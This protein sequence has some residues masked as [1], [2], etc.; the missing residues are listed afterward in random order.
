MLY[1]ANKMKSDHDSPLFGLIYDGGK[2]DVN[3]FI[4]LRTLKTGLQY[5]YSRP[6]RLIAL[7]DI[8][9][10]GLIIQNYFSALKKWQPDA[11]KFPRDYLLLRGAGLWGACFLGAEVIDRVLAQGQYKSDDMLKV[12]S[13]GPHWNWMKGGPF[14]GLSGRAGALKIRDLIAAELSDD[15]GISLKTLMKQIADEI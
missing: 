5:M 2:S 7:E 8:R 9:I 4:P 14:Q 3:K 1:I 13:S 11:W 12:L 10:Q 15:S 6:T